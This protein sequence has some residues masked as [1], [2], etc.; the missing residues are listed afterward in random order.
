LLTNDICLSQQGHTALH[1]A[2]FISKSQAAAE[3][4]ID[5]KAALNSVDVHGRTVLMTAVEKEDLTSLQVLLRAGADVTLRDKHGHT[6]LHLA[7]FERKSQPSVKVLIAK[8]EALN[9]VDGEHRT[10]LMTAVAKQDINSLQIL[11]QAGADPTVKDENGHTALYNALFQIKSYSVAQILVDNKAALNA[12]DGDGKTALMIAAEKVDVPSLQLLLHAGAD[13][14]L[15]DKT[16]RTVLHYAAELGLHDAAMLLLEKQADADVADKEGNT[17]LHIAAMKN[18]SAV[19]DV[20]LKSKAKADCLNKR[21]KWPCQMATNFELKRTLQEAKFAILYAAGTVTPKAMKLC[22]LG[23][24]GAGK[25][26]LV[27]ALKRKWIKSL[28]TWERQRDHPDCQ[29]ERTVGINVSTVDI[30]YVGTFSVYDYA[31]QK[32]FHKTHGL[33]FSALNSLTIL[34][35]SLLTGKERRPCTF[36]ELINEAH[37]WLSFLRASL[38]KEFIP[39]VVIVASRADCCPHGQGMLQQVVNQMSDVFKGKIVIRE[40][41][42][43][44]DCRKSWSPAM[45]LFRRFLKEARDKYLQVRKLINCSDTTIFIV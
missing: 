5:K 3:V 32:Q 16:D 22:V 37:Y 13:I 35:I 30:P 12:M 33:F 42:F 41:C 27:E 6:A 17:P 8:K 26:T 31:G 29:Y 19:V 43:L 18:S 14:T 25:T 36:K 15:R 21:G 10:A 38:G 23:P 45:K 2:L 20:L 1:I 28:F 7:L 11:L 9:S 24:P 39:T 40:E 34:V 4:L 44:L